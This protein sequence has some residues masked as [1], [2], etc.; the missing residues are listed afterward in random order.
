MDKKILALMVK[1]EKS[2]IIPE[3][4]SKNL[5]TKNEGATIYLMYRSSLKP[6]TGGFSISNVSL[7]IRLDP[8]TTRDE[9]GDIKYNGDKITSKNVLLNGLKHPLAI[10]DPDEYA[11]VVE[12]INNWIK[13]N[14]VQMFSSIGL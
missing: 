11:K 4:L 6:N 7:T 3:R 14:D 8:F 9:N 12:V 1:V 13:D 10:K 5:I 2:I